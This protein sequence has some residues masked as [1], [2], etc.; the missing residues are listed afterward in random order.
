MGL[1]MITAALWV[2]LL[3]LQVLHPDHWVTIARRQHLQVL[4]LLPVRGA[5]L[6]RNLKPLAVSIR[7]TSLFANP[8]HVKDPSA[9]ARRLSPLLDQPVGELKA[10]LSQRS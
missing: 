2:R 6:D 5:I 8:R 7:L 9:A 4:K 10:K 3:W 1:L